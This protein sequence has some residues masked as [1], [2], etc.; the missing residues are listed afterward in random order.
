MIAEAIT[1]SAVLGAC[2]AATWF[3]KTRFQP[4]IERSLAR[5]EAEEAMVARHSKTRNN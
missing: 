5:I 3:M 2:T 4:E 1:I